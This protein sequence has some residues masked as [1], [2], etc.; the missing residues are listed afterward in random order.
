MHDYIVKLNH[1]LHPVS[2]LIRNIYK[3]T[4]LPREGTTEES[5]VVQNEDGG[6]R[7]LLPPQ[8]DEWCFKWV[9]R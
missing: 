5:S 8:L 7:E 6:S 3:E 2:I 9:A 1:I 4:E